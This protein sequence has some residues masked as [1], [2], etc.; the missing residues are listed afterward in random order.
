MSYLAD[1]T[2]P[3]MFSS[4]TESKRQDLI[5]NKLKFVANPS[6]AASLLALF[7][8]RRRRNW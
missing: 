7:Q 8:F 1:E 2:V 5:P 3:L 6:G 4:N